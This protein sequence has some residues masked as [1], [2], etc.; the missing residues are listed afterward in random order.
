[1]AWMN[2]LLTILQ[3]ASDVLTAGIAIVA[4]SLLLFAITFKNWEKVT[5]WFTMVMLSV[6]VIFGAD[7]F[8]TAFTNE[9]FLDA[10]L[11][12]HWSG[13]IFLPVFYFHFSDSLLT[14]TGKPS[15]GKRRITG[16]AWL[17]VG[18]TF[19]VLLVS[20]NLIG[21]Y[22]IDEQLG[23]YLERT[24]INDLFSLFFATSLLLSWWNFIRAYQRTITK[25]SR[26]RMIYLIISSL[27]PALGSFP[28]LLYGSQF[29]LNNSMIFWLLSLL[30]AAFVFFSLI[31]MTYSVAFYGFPWPDRVIKSRLFRWVMRG[32]ITASLTL[33]VTTL[34]S[35]LGNQLSINVSALVVLLMVAVIVFFEFFVTLFS[36]IWE[37]LFFYGKDKDE[38]E[39]VRMLEDRL[40]TTNDIRQFLELSLATVCDRLQVSKAALII[41]SKISNDLDTYSK[42][43]ENKIVENKDDFFS[44][45]DQKSSNL[46]VVNEADQF[47]FLLRDQNPEKEMVLGAIVIDEELQVEI[48]EEKK[49]ALE[50]I[51]SRV[52]L[53]LSDRQQQEDLV[54][55]LDLLTPRVSVIQNLLATSRRDKTHLFNGNIDEIEQKEIEKWIK[56]ALTHLWG[57]PKISLNPL[58]QLSIVQEIINNQK[59]T[60]TNAVRTVL[61]EAVNKL[62]PEGERQFTNEWILYNLLDLKFFEGWKVKDIA[63]KLAL[64]EADLYRKQRIA[65]NSVTRNIIESERNYSSGGLHQPKYP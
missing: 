5:I 52:S 28:Y 27:G 33:G 57:G 8:V 16:Y 47:V 48:D 65:I 20:G 1:M 6:M 25:A 30:S 31:A 12:I 61:R 22:T 44:G 64:S 53:A 63:R 60:P 49:I 15:R 7:A 32:P 10:L 26:R 54:S 56:D 40:L 62:K 59:E 35:R 29:A 45:L 14:L 46:S 36:P 4:F 38:L 43:Y 19:L 42:E 24:I 39:K 50:K 37:R 17:I 41:S 23:I 9:N 34:I 13:L 3:A 55:S 58:T 51:I 21:N 2:G 11:M 18:F